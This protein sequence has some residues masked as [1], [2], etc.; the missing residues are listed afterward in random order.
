ME[1]D[2]WAV[3]CRVVIGGRSL[4]K[5]NL[6]KLIVACE[7]AEGDSWKVMCEVPWV[8]DNLLKLNGGN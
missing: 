8:G 2:L 1:G 7:F 5:A 6:W 4:E 3:S